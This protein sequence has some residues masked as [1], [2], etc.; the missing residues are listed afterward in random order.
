MVRASAVTWH[1]P[2]PSYGRLAEPACTGTPSARLQEHFGGQLGYAT[3]Q[4]TPEPYHKHSV[5][6]FENSRKLQAKKTVTLHTTKDF[7]LWEKQRAELQR[8]NGSLVDSSYVALILIHTHTQAE[9]TVQPGVC[10]RS[11]ASSPAPPR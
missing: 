7:S 11:Q 6:D 2:I 3:L 8:F 4:Q 5:R 10:G 1:N 9:R